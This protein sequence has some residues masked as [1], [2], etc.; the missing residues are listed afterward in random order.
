[1]PIF[2]KKT[3]GGDAYLPIWLK[4]GQTSNIFRKRTN[5]H[6]MAN[7]IDRECA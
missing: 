4:I 6:V 1:M 2:E 3:S 7:I 5:E